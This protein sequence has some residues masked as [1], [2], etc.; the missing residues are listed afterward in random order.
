MQCP[1]CHN[2]PHDGARFCSFCG[3]VM[4]E[5]RTHVEQYAQRIREYL[6]DGVLEPW[7]VRELGL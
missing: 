3:S 6:A 2:I 7:E 4:P 5:N 1:S